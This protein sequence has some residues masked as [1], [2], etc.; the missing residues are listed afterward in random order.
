MSI[1]DRAA[2]GGY[3]VTVAEV[4]DEALLR[5]QDELLALNGAEAVVKAMRANM[6]R[7]RTQIDIARSL[8]TS[9]RAAFEG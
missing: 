7:V 8:G 4:E 5:C 2:K 6:V 1:K 3:K 9:V